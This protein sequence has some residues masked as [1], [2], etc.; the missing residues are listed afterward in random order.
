[1]SI[2]IK[3]D[4]KSRKA[5]IKL[6]TLSTKTKNGIRLAFYDIGRDLRKEIRS[7]ILFEQKLGRNYLVRLR[8]RLKRHKASAPGQTGANLSGKYFKSIDYIVKGSNQLEFGSRV[9]HGKFLE[10]GTK[11]MSPRPGLKNAID[12]KESEIERYLQHHIQRELKK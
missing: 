11:H 4:D 5:L 8:G 3:L 1:M 2:K 6:N 9:A 10:E 12:S 7:K